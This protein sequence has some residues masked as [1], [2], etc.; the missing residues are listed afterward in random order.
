MVI[1]D[2]LKV[3]TGELV[4]YPFAAKKVVRSDFGQRA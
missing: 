3:V 2:M 1:E 4:K